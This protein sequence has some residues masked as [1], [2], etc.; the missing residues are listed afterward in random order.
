MMPS[1]KNLSPFVNYFLKIF[2]SK[3]QY[4]AIFACEMLVQ[5]VSG[6]ASPPTTFTM[7]DNLAYNQ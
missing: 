7:N 5:R 3:F 2:R 4:N 1:L 6:S